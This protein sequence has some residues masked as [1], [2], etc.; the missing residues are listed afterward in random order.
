MIVAYNPLPQQQQE[1]I[2]TSINR[3]SASADAG[4]SQS[5]WPKKVK[6]NLRNPFFAT[7]EGEQNLP[8]EIAPLIFSDDEA[9]SGVKEKKEKPWDKL[10][11]YLDKRARARYVSLLNFHRGAF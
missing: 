5:R 3:S 1:D 11:I 6:K 10:D 2:N 4:P 9:E 8:A 7:T